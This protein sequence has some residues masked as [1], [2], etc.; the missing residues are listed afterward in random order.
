LERRKNNN[1]EKTQTSELEQATKNECR[2]MPNH[3]SD[4]T[5]FDKRKKISM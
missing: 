2:T 3:S 4:D 1:K 5:F